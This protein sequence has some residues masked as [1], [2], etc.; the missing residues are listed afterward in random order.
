MR[1]ETG[2]NHGGVEG[3]KMARCHHVGK[4]EVAPNLVSKNGRRKNG[5]NLGRGH[6]IIV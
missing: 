3:G 1:P 5:E 2:G 4:N 6:K